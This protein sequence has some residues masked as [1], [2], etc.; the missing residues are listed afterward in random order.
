MDP[1]VPS[2]TSVREMRELFRTWLEQPRWN[3][4]QLARWLH[5]LDLPPFG[6]DVEPYWFVYR[7]WRLDDPDRESERAEL[8]RRIAEL[9]RTWPEPTADLPRPEKVLFGLLELAGLLKRPHELSGPLGGL[10]DRPEI[11]GEWL[12]SDVRVA[13]RAAL[14]ENQSDEGLRS[15]WVAMIREGGD[16]FLPGGEEE[17]FDAV[18]KMPPVPNV[19]AIGEALKALADRLAHAMDDETKRR[20]EF[21][22]FVKRVLGDTP[23]ENPLSQPLLEAART[24]EWPEPAVGCLF[25]CPNHPDGMVRLRRLVYRTGPL[26]A[27]TKKRGELCGGVVVV[28]DGPQDS[29]EWVKRFA[30]AAEQRVYVAKDSSDRAQAQ[31]VSVVAEEWA[32]E[33]GQRF[34]AAAETQMRERRLDILP[35]RGWWPG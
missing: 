34:G 22:S 4:N 13:L 14:A 17:A 2:P 33:A 24:W 19:D 6:N 32:A 31:E 20:R 26:I 27:L 8:A 29:L 5:G 28:V 1:A 7:E 25:I 9:L 3:P 30:E 11:S 18:L 10:L 21:R 16:P 35:N 23:G 12:G 15:R